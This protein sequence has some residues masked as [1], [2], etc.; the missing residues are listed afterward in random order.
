MFRRA[1]LEGT[2]DLMRQK[3]NEL[4]TKQLATMDKL[5]NLQ[6]EIECCQKLEE[7]LVKS[8][9][10]TKVQ[11]LESEIIQKKKDLR[12]IQRIFQEQTEDVIRSYQKEYNEVTS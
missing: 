10:I 12:E 1:G 2:V 9:Q 6:A 11:S 8:Q 7:E 3:F 5:L 4:V